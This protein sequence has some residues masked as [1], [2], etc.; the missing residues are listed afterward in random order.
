MRFGF[1]AVAESGF[2]NQAC[3]ELSAQFEFKKKRYELWVP[4]RF[5]GVWVG[6]QPAL[7][8][9]FVGS[10][11]IPSRWVMV[12]VDAPALTRM[13]LLELLVSESGPAHMG[14]PRFHPVFSRQV[15]E[16]RRVAELRGMRAVYPEEIAAPL[17]MNP[18]TGALS[19]S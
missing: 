9:R 5:L 7:D 16:E 1:A 12:S 15:S 6:N 17:L 3:A 8:L 4:E 2:L 19:A 11:G 18:M 13:G 10:F 14:A